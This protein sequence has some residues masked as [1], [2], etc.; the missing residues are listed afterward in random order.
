[1]S[2]R[3]PAWTVDPAA[4]AVPED[5]LD[6]D[7]PPLAPL[8]LADDGPS[9]RNQA[10]TLQTRHTITL[11]RARRLAALLNQAPAQTPAVKH[12]GGHPGHRA[13]ND[14]LLELYE[15]TPAHLP[16]LTR[17]HLA[18]VTLHAEIVQR[19]G[20]LAARARVMPAATARD[21]IKEA[22]RRRDELGQD[23]LFTDEQP[24]PV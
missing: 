2:G 15:R 11:R 6:E 19:S 22:R 10:R 20:E 7:D 16:H 24:P 12:K 18:A 9:P 1:M 13:R 4:P 14:R 3:P 8:A 23:E 21:A 5:D 17:C